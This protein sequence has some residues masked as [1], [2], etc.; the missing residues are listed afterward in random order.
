[1]KTYNA[2]TKN[3]PIVL[4]FNDLLTKQTASPHIDETYYDCLTLTDDVR[5][6]RVGIWSA[7]VTCAVTGLPK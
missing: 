2:V 1:M 3:T 5:V 4:F 6:Y 7:L